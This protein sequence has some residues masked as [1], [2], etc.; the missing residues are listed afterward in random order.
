M[1]E[2]NVRPRRALAP[3]D[4][5]DA[6]ADPEGLGAN[7]FARPGSEAAGQ[8]PARARR[9][10]PAEDDVD[11]PSPTTAGPDE[12]TVVVP[13]V[14]EPE[15]MIPA[16]VLPERGEG[17]FDGPGPQPRRSALSSSS[18]PEPAEPDPADRW[19]PEAQ[20]SSG[21]DGGSPG[22]PQSPSGPDGAEPPS[23]DAPKWW[24]AHAKGIIASGAAVALLAVG[25]GVLGYVQTRPSGEASPTPSPTVSASPSNSIPRLRQDI[26][27]NEADA[28]H[29][30][31]NAD[32]A[33]TETTTKLEEHSARPA[34]LSTE[35]S[36]VERLDSFQRTLGTTQKNQLAVLHQ[37][38]AFPTEANAKQIYD[39]RA[40]AL[41]RC[42]EV[43]TLILHAAKVNGLG[44]ESTQISVV[45]EGNPRKYHDILLTRTGTIVSILDITSANPGPGPQKLVEALRRSATAVCDGHCDPT[46]AWAQ[47]ADV[48]PVDPRGWL[49]PGDL[50]RI[51]AGAGMWTAQQPTTISSKGTG[52]EDL[53]LASEAGPKDRKQATYL[54]AQDPQTPSEFGLDEFRFT[55]ADAGGA[56]KFAKKLGDN[57]GKCQDRVLGTTVKA[58]K[59]A[60][61]ERAYDIQ[62]KTAKDAI[63][64]Q[65]A[66]VR[67]G[68]KVAYLLANVTEDYRFTKPA[69]G[70]ITTRTGVRL[71]QG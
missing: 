49:I 21:G 66:I 63:S 35:A 4:S 2:D 25:A 67:H 11:G 29:V 13:R 68:N 40:A 10:L 14:D 41:A 46:N 15:P 62:R 55:F 9:S 69:F 22:S 44:N 33:I 19:E 51:R 61:A 60:G 32:W 53:S 64:Y 50:P 31:P 39:T 27:F 1:S 7:P 36:D 47:T 52:C 3:D 5:A 48:P 37:L 56:A 70:S 45:E 71:Q 58:T 6:P 28:K 20:P 17:F 59:A 23:G 8:P 18:P 30:S 38:D 12:D 57:L 26:L 34:C 42:N 24:Q 16:P 54:V 65:V 43:P